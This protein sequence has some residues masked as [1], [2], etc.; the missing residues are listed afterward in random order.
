MM[1][2]IMER[3]K[4]QFGTRP[5][6]VVSQR[7][8]SRTEEVD[9]RAIGAGAVKAGAAGALAMAL[10]MLIG[11][12]DI[13]LLPCLVVPGFILVLIAGGMLAGLFANERLNSPRQ[14][15]RA[16]LLAGLVTGL[17]AAFVAV[18]LAAF[19][20]MFTTLGEGVRAQFTPGQLQNL[21][22]MGINPQT[23]RIA[24]AVFFALLIWG[25]FGTIVAMALGTL[26]AWLYYRL[27]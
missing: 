26:G 11:S 15:L 27:R 19:G 1:E 16:G 7:L 2:R 12:V 5:V 22:E 6:K 23:V 4:D 25:V 20:L 14:A 9:A 24:G 18:L 17:G 3:K 13:P 10:L 8:A 21:A